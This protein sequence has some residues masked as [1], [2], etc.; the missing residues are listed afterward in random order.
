MRGLSLASLSFLLACALPAMAQAPPDSASG[1]VPDSTVAPQ[2]SAR[3]VFPT[4]GG[5]FYYRAGS[6]SGI[7]RQR[8]REA[9]APSGDSLFVARPDAQSPAAPSEPA[10]QR[11]LTRL[12]ERVLRAVDRRIASQERQRAERAVREG[13]ADPTR[14][15]QVVVVPER[16]PV[17]TGSPTTRPTPRDPAPEAS[18]RR[19]PADVLAPI[20]T[21]EQIER[22]ILD[23]GLFRTTFVNFEFARAELIPLSER[24]L[25]ALATVLLRYPA[26][27]I[28]VGGHTD[29][30]DSDAT[31]DRL[32]QERADSVVAYLVD[33]GI[34]RQRL[35]AV[36]YGERRP[37]A[38]NETETGRALNRRVEFVV[39]NPGAA[40]RERR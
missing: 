22:D 9:V 19:P 2:R 20:A 12:E 35:T 40:Q 4:E 13:R 18:P 23:T 7:R 34:A 39:L 38:S 5:V 16:T 26:L 28:Q 14:P 21:P 1:A 17:Q 36:G 30:R 32:S 29:S 3:L 37:V 8:L 31:N 33:H 15:G 11:D 27:R 24:T 25:D 6:G 10:L